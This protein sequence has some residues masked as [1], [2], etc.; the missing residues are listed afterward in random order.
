M[1][2]APVRAVVRRSE[3]RFFLTAAFIVAAVVLVGFSRTFYL[4]GYFH[5]PPLLPIVQVHGA[6]F[7]GW[8]ALFIT[9]AWLVSARRTRL[10][11]QL[12]MA[13]FVLALAMVGVGTT[14][15]IT[16]A[17]LGHVP[18]GAPPPLMF[19]VVPLFDMLVFSVLIAAGFL[20][21]RRSDY[22]K[23]IMV[24]ATAA[25]MTAAFGRIVLMV[26][27][28][29]NVI[30]AF[31]LTD[32]LVVAA[33]AVDAFL[34]RRL[35]PAFVWAGALLILSQPLRFAVAHTQPWMNFARWLTS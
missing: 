6:L 7:S 24:V 30:L 13:G 15:A 27:G 9:Q 25:L 14:T 4:K 11:M 26:Q 2:T 20:L 18:P 29:G 35:H 33:A 32:L 31:T 1:A 22:H 34:H 17:R 8:V 5:T 12:G 3:H 10:H 19:L 16:M 21:R 28:T 23:R